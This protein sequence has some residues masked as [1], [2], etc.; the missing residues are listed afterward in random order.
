[1]VVMTSATIWGANPSD[2]SSSRSTR[3]FDMSARPMASICCS[4][5]ESEPAIR[6]WRSAR[7]GNSAHAVSSVHGAGAPSLGRRGHREVLAHGQTPEHAA[8]L[9]HRRNPMGGDHLGGAPAHSASE[10]GDRAVPGWEEAEGH[11]HRRRL[12]GAVAPEHA[13]QPALAQPQ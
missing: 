7:R 12:A 8:V 6:F 2:G 9:G 10:H 1:M 5:P 13:E 3:G 11:A 4:P